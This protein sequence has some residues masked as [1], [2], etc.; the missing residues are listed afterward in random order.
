ME[1]EALKAILKYLIITPKIE[2]L[3]MKKIDLVRVQKYEEAAKVREQEMSLRAELPTH[4]ELQ[5][6]YDQLNG[7]T[8]LNPF[9]CF[10]REPHIMDFDGPNQEEE[11]EDRME[12]YR[13]WDRE[14]TL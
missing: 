13:K 9:A 11:Y 4:E 3:V 10:G 12:N 14:N 7:K 1:K 2:E 6:L 5:K 8:N